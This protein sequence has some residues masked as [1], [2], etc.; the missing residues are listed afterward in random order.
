MSSAQGAVERS[1]AEI[2]Q[3]LE[4]VRGAIRMRVHPRDQSQLLDAADRIQEACL[5]ALDPSAIGTNIQRGKDSARKVLRSR[6]VDMVQ[7]LNELDGLEQ[8]ITK[9]LQILNKA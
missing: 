9:L 5:N 6:P 2:K 7:I 8:E 1:K 4:R 3:I